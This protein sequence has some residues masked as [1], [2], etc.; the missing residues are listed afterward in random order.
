MPAALEAAADRLRRLAAWMRSPRRRQAAAL[1]WREGA[2]GVEVLLV[3]TRRTGRWTP[4]KG[5]LDGDESAE[6]AAAREA[7]EE[8]GVI[9]RAS[10]PRL[11]EYDYLKLTKAGRWERVRV[12]LFPVRVDDLDVDFPETGLRSACWAA[13]EDAGRMVRERPLG[14][15]IAAFSPV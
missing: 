9:G 13:P 11:G 4:P 5:G 12:D 10:G 14:R 3:T 2:D 8:A 7:W 6:E 1:C 15:L